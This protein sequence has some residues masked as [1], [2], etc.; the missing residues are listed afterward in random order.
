[1]SDRVLIVDDEQAI[2]DLLSQYL[3]SQGYECVVAATAADAMNRLEE[4]SIALLL[5]DLGL[6]DMEGMEVVRA[7]RESDPEIGVVVVTGL[8]EV[9]SAVE[10]MRAGADDY[11]MK[12]LNFDEMMVSLS[13]VMEKRNLVIENRQYQRDLEARVRAATVDLEQTNRELGNTKKYLENLLH[14]TVDAIVTVDNAGKMIF[15]NEG[16]VHMLGYSRDELKGMPA[17][18]LFANG[19]D[20]V[21]Y[22][23]RAVRGAK[24]LKNYETDIKHKDGRLI[25]VSMSLSIVPDADGKVSSTLAVCKDIT[26]QRRLEQQLREMSIKDSLTGLYNHRHFYERL[27]SE[28][29]RARRQKHALSL[30]LIDL[31]QFKWYNDRHG[32]LAG[33]NVL[34][35]VGNVIRECTREHVDLGFRYGGD[36]FTVILP[37]ADEQQATNIAERV[38]S[39]FTAYDFGRISMSIG[40]MEYETSCPVRKFIQSTDAMMYEAKRRGGDLICTYDPQVCRR[41]LQEVEGITTHA[42]DGQ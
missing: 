41:V 37:E 3:G 33:D 29:E 18:E 11:L 6:P 28:I 8:K 34:R 17:T 15:V 12:P 21:D 16:G 27:E 13:K 5:I 32:H 22:L 2:R 14:S 7:V 35:T 4:D 10:A 25:P 23:R 42:K 9:E 39:K 24:R 26:E 30:I 1:M 38:K 19:A 20:E 40:V 36:E 31:D